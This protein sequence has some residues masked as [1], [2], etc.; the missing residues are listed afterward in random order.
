[1]KTIEFWCLFFGCLTIVS[2]LEH[3]RIVRGNTAQRGQFP[4]IVSLRH[5]QSNQHFCGGTILSDVWIVTAARCTT[6][7]NSQL[8]KIIAVVGA[9]YL[10]D[11]V[12]HRPDRIVNHPQFSPHILTDDIA[13]IHTATKIVFVTNL[14]QP[15]LL[16]TVDISAGGRGQVVI[17]GW[18]LLKVLWCCL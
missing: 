11:G 5:P 17:P 8:D 18:G 12:V 3:E 7:V 13:L 6:Y 1:M 15:I 9:Y 16:P 14:I 4:Y 10:T 2:A